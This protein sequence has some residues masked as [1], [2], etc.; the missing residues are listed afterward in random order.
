MIAK[1]GHVQTSSKGSIS[2]PYGA[3][4][5][6]RKL[7]ELAISS[8]DEPP[9]RKSLAPIKTPREV[10]VEDMK[11]QFRQAYEDLDLPD[12][13]RQKADRGGLNLYLSGGGFRGWGYLLM[14]KHRVSPYPVPIINGFCVTKRDF[15]Q[16]EEMSTLAA[17]QSVFRISKRR[18]AQVPAVAFL[19]GI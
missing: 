8:P 14:A 2:F 10:L 1:D 9:R 6:T 13:L 3:A 17:E 5:M 4:A 11:A 18:A 15:T 16:T 19:V 7:E 12:A